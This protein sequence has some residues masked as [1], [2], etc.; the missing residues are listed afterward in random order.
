MRCPECAAEVSPLREYCPQCGTPIH[1]AP[2]E[3]RPAGPVPR[4]EEELKRN[5]RNVLV[6][7]AAILLTVGVVGKISWFGP[8]IDIRSDERRRGPAVVKAEEVFQAYRRDARAADRQFRR[9]EM[10]V[11]GEFLRITPDGQG[12]PDLRLKTTDP[13]APLGIDLIRASHE[14]AMQLR[15]GQTVTVSCQRV[16]RTGEERWL[17]NC[18]IQTVEGSGAAASPSAPGESPPIEGNKAGS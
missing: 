3:G 6:I 16:N 2:R 8:S 15:P 17:Q 5:R 12:D 10:V 7:G 4:S 14:Q 13:E 11:T 18:A 9:R 1:R